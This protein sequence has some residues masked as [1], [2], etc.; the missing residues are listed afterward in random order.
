[1]TI[2][3]VKKG[4]QPNENE[5]QILEQRIG[6]PLPLDYRA[7]L[8]KNNGGIPETNI[9]DLPACNGGSGINEFLSIKEILEQKNVMKDR[10]PPSAWPIAFAEGGNYVCLVCEGNSGVY[11]WDHE[12]EQ[13]DGINPNWDNMYELSSTFREFM[14][15]IR[16]FNINDVELK[17]EQ[18]KSVWVDPDFKPEF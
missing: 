15:A 16:K 12:F 14:Q 10:L 18:V 4:Q 17:P 7:F 3:I 2:K 8:E 6:N 11:F 5:I 13:E 1:M 9:F